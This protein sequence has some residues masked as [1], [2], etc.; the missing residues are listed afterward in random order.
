M[1]E[2]H[3]IMQMLFSTSKVICY[4]LPAHVIINFLFSAQVIC[5]LFCVHI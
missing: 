2:A 5:S 3:L 1:Y 4:L